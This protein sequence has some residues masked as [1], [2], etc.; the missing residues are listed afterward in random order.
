VAFDPLVEAIRSALR[1]ID[2]SP[3]TASNYLHLIDA[4]A[5]C[6]DKE[7]EIELLEQAEYVI[8]DTK[9]L[10]LSEEEQDRLAKLESRIGTLF[11]RLRE[12][13]GK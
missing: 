2:A 13:S 9:M 8:R 7:S 3:R 11:A 6:A 5:N 4:Y 12:P 10:P 1:A